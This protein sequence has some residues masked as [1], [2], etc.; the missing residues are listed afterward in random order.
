MNQKPKRKIGA[1]KKFYEASLPL[2]SSKVHL[3]G[4]EL[5][6]FEGKTILLDMTK[7]LRGKNLILK[8]KL[9]NNDGKL[10]GELVSLQLIT[11][12]IRKV[13]RRGTDYVEDSFATECK[14][15]TIRIKPFLITRNSVSRAIRNNLR[16]ATKKHIISH[17]T[18][19]SAQEIFSEVI[20]NKLQKEISLKLKQIYPLALCEIRMLEIES[21]S[22]P[23]LEKSNKK[24]KAS[25]QD[26]QISSE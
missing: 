22:A 23:K 3:Y 17:C 18:I 9:K 21:K 26:A 6:E 4:Y 1:K 12:Y 19:R 15:A 5:E 2:V 16:N 25:P 14:D 13:M 11:S 24:S 10:E 20:S 7:N 8:A